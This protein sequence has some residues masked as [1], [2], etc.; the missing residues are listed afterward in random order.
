MS[1]VLH[2]VGATAGSTSSSV[3]IEMAS[4][5]TCS[6]KIERVCEFDRKAHYVRPKHFSASTKTLQL[7]EKMVLL[8]EVIQAQR[9]HDLQRHEKPHAVSIFSDADMTETHQ[10]WMQDYNSW[11]HTET[12]NIYTKHR[13][14]PFGGQLPSEHM[15]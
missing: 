7:L 8:V 3:M 5:R 1:I 14:A 12:Q 9:E 15:E 13:S 4:C 2:S 11:M 10:D 6:A